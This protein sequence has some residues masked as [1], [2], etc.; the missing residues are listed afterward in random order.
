MKKAII[1]SFISMVIIILTLTMMPFA[2]NA[3]IEWKSETVSFILP[4][5]PNTYNWTN[6]S[7]ENVN[8]V[9]LAFYEI[10]NPLNRADLFFNQDGT[11]LLGP[12]PV[13]VTGIGTPNISVFTNMSVVPGDNQEVI[14]FRWGEAIREGELEC[15]T[16]WIN[17]DNNFEFIFDRYYGSNNWVKIYDMDGEL[18][19]EID[20]AYGDNRFEVDLPDGMYMVKTFHDDMDTP[21]QEFLIG[22]PGP[23]M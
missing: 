6:P 19:W 22:K 10:A 13:T 11:D 15:K 20:F 23:E 3:D 12:G 18:V 16:V 14:E 1:L 9:V 8:F 7:G 21:I 4:P 5:G 2:L 17:E